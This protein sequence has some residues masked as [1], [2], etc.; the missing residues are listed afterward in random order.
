MKLDSLV[1]FVVLLA[2]GTPASWAVEGASRERAKQGDCP[3]FRPA[4]CLVYEPP[5]CYSDWHCPQ[6]QKC[7]RGPC[8][9]QCLDPV[10]QSQPGNPGQCPVVTG[11]CMMLNPRDSCLSDGDCPNN[12]KCCEGMCGKLCVRPV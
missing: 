9:I 6:E 12:F 8:G 2:L 3:F 1:A 10:D 5:E 7:C 4:L 11:Q